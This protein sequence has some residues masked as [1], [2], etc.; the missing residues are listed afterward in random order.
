MNLLGTLRASQSAK[1]IIEFALT[2]NEVHARWRAFWAVSRLDRMTTLLPLRSALRSRIPSRRWRAALMLSVLQQSEAGTVLVGGLKS[3]SPWERWEALSAIK[4]LRL[5]G[6]EKEVA[7]CLKANEPR[8]IRQQAALTL[9]SIGTDAARRAL[10][11]AL[12]DPEPEV[13]WRASMAIA[14][15]GSAAIPT[16]KSRL[17]RESDQSVR[18]QIKSDLLRLGR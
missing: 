8:Y 4:S 12:R 2:E 10:A 11:R 13:R 15:Y 1:S 9:G 16:L 14:G 17:K 7:R 6:C 5:Y 18:A 3:A